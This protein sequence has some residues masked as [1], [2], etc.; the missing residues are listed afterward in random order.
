[1]RKFPWL[2]VRTALSQAIASRA[3]FQEHSQS[4]SDQ[5]NAE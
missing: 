3:A 4:A 2:A 1:M 5:P